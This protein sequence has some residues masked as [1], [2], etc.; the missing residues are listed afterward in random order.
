MA[1][2]RELASVQDEQGGASQVAFYNT[3]MPKIRAF[4]GYDQAI[5]Q[6]SDRGDFWA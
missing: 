5:H 1:K 2:G 6:D 4:S 3:N